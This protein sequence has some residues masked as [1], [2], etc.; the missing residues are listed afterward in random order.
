MRSTFGAGNF[1]TMRVGGIVNLSREVA[2]DV[3]WG[4]NFGTEY[5]AFDYTFD[6]RKRGGDDR[7]TARLD[8]DSNNVTASVGYQRAWFRT[9][10]AI[11]GRLIPTQGEPTV[12]TWLYGP[13]NIINAR[14][15]YRFD[16]HWFAYAEGNYSWQE[17]NARSLSG[18][19]RTWEAHNANPVKYSGIAGI[20]F[21]A[22]PWTF[23]LQGIASVDEQNEMNPFD[24]VERAEFLPRVSRVGVE[25]IANWKISNTDFLKA[26]VAYLHVTGFGGLPDGF[27][28]AYSPADIMTIYLSGNFKFTEG[29]KKPPVLIT[30]A[31]PA[32]PSFNWAGGYI[33][34]NL[35][36]HWSRSA[37]D[38][39]F[40]D[41]VFESIGRSGAVLATASSTLK[42]NGIAAGGQ[43]GYNWQKDKW[44]WG[45]E[46]DFQHAGQTASARFVC[47]AV[48]CGSSGSDVVVTLNQRL[49]WF[50]T[51]RGRVGLA[52]TPEILTYITGG[53]AYGEIR[54]QGSLELKTADIVCA[55]CVDLETGVRG[56]VI[57]GVTVVDF[58]KVNK[59]AIGWAVG[60]GVESRLVGNWTVRAEYM[61]VDFAP[62][63][64]FAETQFPSF[65]PPPAFNISFVTGHFNSRFAMNIVRGG[66]NYKFN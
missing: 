46:G 18:G 9:D 45:V 8:Y 56:I 48:N 30:K 53:F 14:G 52:L 2:L 24:P 38:T 65:Q 60:A 15:E 59:P 32:A 16:D 3:S 10:Q 40:N 22:S 55:E 5:G 66:F 64:Y 61:H 19:I 20:G 28:P 12:Q 49:D 43:A 11:Y 29:V 17:S 7:V 54:S 31:P 42:F 50:A 51:I 21:S 58:F 47:P 41:E 27:P 6:Q 33:G 35:G 26:R 44:V 63:E 4:H 13:L 57:P 1:F 25:G 39:T 62:I 37:T 34:G 23:Q 36:Y